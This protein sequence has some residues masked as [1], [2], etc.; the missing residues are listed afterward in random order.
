MKLKQYMKFLS[1]YDPNLTVGI[2]VITPQNTELW[3]LDKSSMRVMDKGTSLT[4]FTA[5]LNRTTNS[6]LMKNVKIPTVASLKCT[7]DEI[8][9]RI[10]ERYDLE[11][12][13]KTLKDPNDLYEGMMAIRTVI[14]LDTEKLLQLL[15]DVNCVLWMYGIMKEKEKR[16]AK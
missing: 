13:E 12:L 9:E 10:K 6:R 4:L 1:Q 8:W 5:R 15:E 3:V 11:E 7:P 16:D 14:Q 2:N